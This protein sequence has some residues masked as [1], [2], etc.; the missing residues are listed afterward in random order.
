MTASLPCALFP[1]KVRKG[2]GTRLHF[3]YG[4]SAPAE[5]GRGHDEEQPPSWARPDSVYRTTP[6]NAFSTQLPY[7]LYTMDSLPNNVPD[8]ASG[9]GPHFTSKHKRVVIAAANPTL[10]PEY[11]NQRIRSRIF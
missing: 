2:M 7:I 5:W 3:D 9:N 11:V 4:P 10:S 8:I 1:V 6:R